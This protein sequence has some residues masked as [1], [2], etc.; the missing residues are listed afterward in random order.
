VAKTIA[1]L[2]GV[3]ETLNVRLETARQEISDLWA[4]HARFSEQ[5]QAC[6]EEA[7][8]D[9][10]EAVRSREQS[11]QA[12]RLL[13]EAREAIR[14]QEKAHAELRQENAVLRQQLAD[15]IKQ[16]EVGDSRR[17]G[18][19]VLLITATLSLLA[20]LIVSLTKKS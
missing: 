19:F 16:V 9:R 15:H 17:W 3:C 12:R 18:L 8:R 11:E 13:D 1:E 20:T 2:S 6:R 4:A 14:A 7:A 5:L 10:A